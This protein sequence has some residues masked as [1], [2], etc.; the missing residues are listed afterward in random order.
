M[1][2]NFKFKGNLNLRNFH[3]DWK[4]EKNFKARSHTQDTECYY[5]NGK[6][7]HLLQ[8]VLSLRRHHHDGE[9]WYNDIQLWRRWCK[10]KETSVNTFDTPQS[11]LIWFFFFVFLNKNHSSIQSSKEIHSVYPQT[12]H[13]GY[14]FISFSPFWFKIKSSKEM[15][16][17]ILKCGENVIKSGIIS[18]LL[19]VFP[20]RCKYKFMLLRR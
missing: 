19:C 13:S 16:K 6:Q 2:L 3:G 15:C 10:I 18:F 17:V 9:V 14:P 1:T 12:I 7:H 8:Y 4:I 20:S 5:A 11:P